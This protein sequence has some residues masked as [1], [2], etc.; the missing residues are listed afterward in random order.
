MSGIVQAPCVSCTRITAHDILYTVPQIGS[1]DFRQI[2][3]TLQCRGCQSV[4]M[5]ETSFWNHNGENKY[6]LPSIILHP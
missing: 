1:G 2:F 4:S 6:A 3:D 5:R